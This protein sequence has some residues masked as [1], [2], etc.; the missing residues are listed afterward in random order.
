MLFSLLHF[1][2]TFVVSVRIAFCVGFARG[3]GGFLLKFY[4]SSRF[5]CIDFTFFQI[6]EIMTTRPTGGLLVPI[7]GS[8]RPATKGVFIRFYT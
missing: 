7:R 8:Y 3:F 5:V 2:S 6:L 4:N 1:F